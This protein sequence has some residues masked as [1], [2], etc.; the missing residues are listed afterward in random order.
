[1]RLTQQGVHQ[2]LTTS[3][4]CWGSEGWLESGAGLG[5]HSTAPGIPRPAPSQSP[6]KS[7]GSVGS[8]M[9]NSQQV[10]RQEVHSPKYQCSYSS[11]FTPVNAWKA[12]EC[13]CLWNEASRTAKPHGEVAAEQL[14][15]LTHELGGCLLQI[16]A[17]EIF[18]FYLFVGFWGH[19]SSI[20]Q[21]PM[22]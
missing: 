12:G 5:P 4:G 13:R 19:I 2:L 15:K 6:E 16:Y 14:A 20:L 22:K 7:W 3:V 11:Q 10:E 18:Q 1:M 8:E 17:S 9:G 21:M